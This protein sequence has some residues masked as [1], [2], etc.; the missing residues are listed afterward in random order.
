MKRLKCLVLFSVESDMCH[1]II[2]QPKLAIQHDLQFGTVQPKYTHVVQIIEFMKI[3]IQTS[4]H[5]P[6]LETTRTHAATPSH[7][8]TPSPEP[9]R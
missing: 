6:S 1:N 9:N 3:V 7:H 5:R 8:R 4:F 2:S